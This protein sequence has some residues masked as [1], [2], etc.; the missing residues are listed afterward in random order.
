MDPDEY[1]NRIIHLLH[2]SLKDAKRNAEN[3]MCLGIS[4]QRATFITFDKHSGKPFHQLISWK[5]QRGDKITKKFNKS[6]LLKVIH[7]G[8]DFLHFFTRS[9]KFKQTK[10]L[11]LEN[12]FVAPRLSKIIENNRKLK[13]A[14]RNGRAVFATVDTWLMHRLRYVNGLE[15]YEPVTEITNASAT[16]LFDPFSMTYIQAFLKYFKI[17]RSVLPA[18]VDN[19]HDFGYTHKSIFGIPIKIATIIADQ[20][21]SLIGNGCFRNMDAKITLGTGAFLHINTG[22]KCVGSANGAYPLVAWDL[23]KKKMKPSVIYFTERSFKE[24]NDV[25]KIATTI[26]LCSDVKELSEMAFSVKNSNGVF[27]IPKFNSM[28]GFYG[29]KNSSKKEHLVRAILE[30]IVFHVGIFFFRTEEETSYHFEKIRID[31]GI[32][33]NDFICQHIADLINVPI[34]RSQVAKEL[35]SYGVAYLSAYLNNVILDEL[36][37]SSKLYKV[38]KIFIPNKD[39]RKEL[40]MR[41]KKYEELYKIYKNFN[42]DE[43]FCFL[44]LSFQYY[45]KNIMLK[46]GALIVFEGCDRAGKTTQCKKLVERL[47]NQNLNVKFMNFPNRET[48]SGKIIDAYLRNKET[49]TDEGIHLL[50]T[51]NRWEAKKEMEQELLKGTTIIVDRYSYSGVAFSAAKGLDFEWCKTPEKGLLKPDLVIYLT[52]SADAM[53]R[54]EGFGNERYE[55][56]EMQN[57]VKTIYEKMI[58]TP[59]WQIVDADKTEEALTD[60]LENII[61][62]RMRILDKN[63]KTMCNDF[64]MKIK[65]LQKAVNVAWSPQRQ[66]PILLAAGTA[67]QQVLDTSLNSSNPS[68]ELYSLN[69]SEP[70]YDLDLIGVQQSAHKFH[71]IVWSPFDNSEN[72]P[73]GVIVGGCESGLMKIYNVS[74]ILAGEDGLVAQSDKHNG[75]VRTIDYNPFKSNLIASAASESEIFIWDVNNTSVPMTPG[76]KTQP[77]EDVC[78]VAWNRQV[79]HILASSFATKCVIWDLRKNE[80]IIKLSDTQSRVRWRVVQ[81]HPD[82]A[83]QLWLASED[84]QSPVIQLWDLRYATAPSKTLQIHSRG[85]LG[86]AW[87]PSDPSLMM[88]CAKDNKILCWDA[89]SEDSHGEVLSEIASTNQWYSDIS[90]CPRNPAIVAASSFDANVS[91]YSIFGGSQQQVQTTSKIADSFPGM[92]QIPHENVHQQASSQSVIFHDLKRPPKWLKRPAGISFGFGG[93]LVTFN[94]ENRSLNIKQLITDESLVKRSTELENVLVQGNYSDYCIQKANESNDQH[95]RFIWYFLKAYFEE[96]TTNEFLN[97][98]GYQVEDI[99]NKFSKI[100]ESKDGKGNHDFSDDLSKKMANLNQ[101]DSSEESSSDDNTDLSNQE[102][103]EMNGTTNNTE[104][105][106]NVPFKLTTTGTEGLICEAL[107]TGNISA[108]VELCMNAGRSTDAII[109]ASLGGSDLLARTQYRYL[110][111]NESFIS[112]LIS[113]MVMADWSGVILQCTIDSWKE[114]LVAALTHSRDQSPLLCERLGERLQIESDGDDS[115]VKNSILCYICAGNIERIVDAWSTINGADSTEDSEKLQ[116]LVEVVVLLSK[117]MERK[118]KTVPVYG[119]YAELLSKYASL[120]A[121][122]GSLDMALTYIGTSQDDANIIDLRERLYYALGHKQQQQSAFNQKSNSAFQ[123]NSYQ[124]NAP[125][126]SQPRTISTSSNSGMPLFQ[127]Q[128]QNTFNTGLPNASSGAM[129]LN[130]HF[131]SNPSPW[132]PPAPVSKPPPTFMNPA[133]N[134]TQPARP[135]SVS[136]VGSASQTTSL[137]KPRR[138]LDPS[139]QSGPSY[140]QIPVQSSTMFNQPN[141]TFNSNPIQPVQPMFN[142]LPINS[143]PTTMGWEQQGYGNGNGSLPP[144]PTSTTQQMMKNPTPPPGWNDPPEFKTKSMFQSH[145]ND[146]SAD[147]AGTKKWRQKHADGHQENKKEVTVAAPI[148]HPIFGVAEPQQQYPGSDQMYQQQANYGGQQFAPVPTQIPPPMSGQQQQQQTNF[149][150]QPQQQQQQPLAQQ[151]VN[152][153]NFQTFPGQQQPQQTMS[154]PPQPTQQPPKQ[155]LPLPE[156]FIYLQTVLDELKSQCINAAGNPQ[157]KR[158]LEDVSKRLEILYDLLRENRLST[159]TLESLNQLVQLIQIGDYGNGLGLHTQMVSGPDFSK[160]ASFMPGIKIL[161]QLAMQ[162]QVYLR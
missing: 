98:L 110:K 89:N 153:Q 84:D 100:M 142:P 136:S 161:L 125:R 59:L 38:D 48:Q 157:T 141:P 119:K 49:L 65:E 128:P 82:V 148:T 6:L 95:N 140:G 17:K 104:S 151:Q 108:A 12:N 11:K 28:T 130:N 123:Q 147:H 15:K 90:W 45:N 93:K 117:A 42:L 79:Q 73:N 75:P 8:S 74:K 20:S 18:I 126:L 150:Q 44:K 91:I 23:T 149:Y 14:M 112:N 101:I 69:L 159:S 122:Q 76:A 61:H 56:K 86:M 37:N 67:A 103:F 13:D 156:E 26:G 71:K 29:Y 64:N 30:T 109:L 31:G 92:E 50:F 5:D 21:A 144:P 88:S 124:H 80:P 81:W 158:K 115:I 87:C 58:E 114:A 146:M 9:N 27:F 162:L 52:L 70:G 68:L 16:S 135:A 137:P 47:K 107:L 2:D 66:I 85:V 127:P 77:F 118:G 10:N 155:K 24:S 132:S 41:Y 78:G 83:T 121:A 99:A 46:R 120:L 160:I 129:T 35:T 63:I 106:T 105:G 133:E 116:E 32:S 19:S 102:G 22:N 3:V 1:F 72:Y 97:L 34:E 33:E 53:A 36:E 40:F 154:P 138:L 60:E 54:R 143:Q 111:G 131:D 96:N 94:S 134:L 57:N 62:E 25:I 152:F 4:V 145:K 55:T 39:N 43:C 113:A 51:V 139:V 7:V